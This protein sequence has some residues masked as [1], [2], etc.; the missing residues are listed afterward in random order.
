MYERNLK[1]REFGGKP[2]ENGVVENEGKFSRSRKYSSWS[3]TAKC[4]LDLAITSVVILIRPLIR[5]VVVKSEKWI[6]E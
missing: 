2:E 4:P 6:K 3:N 1:S 5:T